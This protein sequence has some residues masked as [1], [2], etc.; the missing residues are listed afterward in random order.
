MK[1]VDVL[2]VDEN[3]YYFYLDTIAPYR[4]DKTHVDY[5]QKALRS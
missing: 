4:D 5:E 2:V 1:D 3:G